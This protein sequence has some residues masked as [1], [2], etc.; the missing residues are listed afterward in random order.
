MAHRTVQPSLNLAR[1]P[2]YTLLSEYI[3]VPGQH[4]SLS[5]RLR[6]RS[7]PWSPYRFTT[8]RGAHELFT[9]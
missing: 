7:L 1:D 8:R 3:A 4:T 9:M 5:Q 6:W 2:D